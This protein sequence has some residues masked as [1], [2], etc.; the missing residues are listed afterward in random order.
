MKLCLVFLLS[1]LCFSCLVQAQRIGRIGLIRAK[2]EDDEKAPV[3]A[4]NEEETPVSETPVTS[5]PTTSAPATSTPTTSTPTT[6]S[7]RTT[8][9]KTSAPRTRGG[10]KGNNKLPNDKAGS[11]LD[12]KSEDVASD[13]DGDNSNEV[14]P[15]EQESGLENEKSAKTEDAEKTSSGFGSLLTVVFAIGGVV[16]VLLVATSIRNKLQGDYGDDEFEMPENYRVPPARPTGQTNASAPSYIESGMSYT[17]PAVSPGRNS[18]MS[19][20]SPGSRYSCTL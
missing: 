5:A 18:A 2:R 15:E 12:E 14:V 3:P 1:V 7:P 10:G 11:A 8:S 16:L 13:K 6:R 17:P 19:V 9:P 20:T 4:D